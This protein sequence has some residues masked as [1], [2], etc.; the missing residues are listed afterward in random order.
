MP[1]APNTGSNRKAQIAGLG[2]Q[3]RLVAARQWLTP[4]VPNGGRSVPES[5]VRSKGMTPEGEKKTVDLSQQT[6]YWATPTTNE[7]TGPGAGPNKTGAPN[8]R[9]QTD[10]W[11][12][13]RGTDGTHGG[14]NQAGSKG[15]LMLPSAA[16]QWPTPICQDAKQ[17]GHAPSGPG[18][19]EKL[20]FT[21]ANWT[22]P[23]A[24][25]AKGPNSE[26]HTTT[27][28]GGQETHGSISQLCSAH[29]AGLFA[30]G[31]A[32]PRWASII[33][34]HPHVAPALEPGFRSVVNGL[35]FD[36]DDCRAQRLKCVGNGVVALC[37]AAAF[38]VLF[39][40]SGITP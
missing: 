38:V 8:L 31:P 7:H 36:M 3:A 17:S 40:R 33:S 29:A 27:T 24:R 6:R 39:Q 35:A 23:A 20:S 10:A 21:A 9:T 1:E 5:L 34:H 13:P 37:A 18:L 22:T 32:D 2:N 11:P 16:A 15:D 30:P 14:P 28:G 26:L 12:T 25:D 4:N 19:A